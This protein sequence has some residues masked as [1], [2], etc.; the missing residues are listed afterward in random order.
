MTIS[1]RSAIS[2][3]G[4]KRDPATTF[5]DEMDAVCA[6]HTVHVSVASTVLVM[7]IT[8]TIISV[9]AFIVSA[10]TAWL[11]LL[12]RGALRMTHPTVIFFGPDGPPSQGAEIKIFLRTLLYSTAKHAHILESLYVTLRRGESVQ[13][14]N[15]WVYGDHSPLLRGSG[16]R[17][18]EDGFA[19]NHHFVLPKDGTHYAFIAGEYT[20][21]VYATLVNSKAVLMSKTRL[22]LTQEHATAIGRGFGVYFDWG[23]DSKSYH[24]HIDSRPAYLLVASASEPSITIVDITIPAP[25][26]E[27]KGIEYP[28]KCYVQL[29]NDSPECADI[30]ISEFKPKAVTLKKFPVDVLQ[31]KLREWSPK[32]EGVDHVAILPGQLF[33]AWIGADE[34]KFTHDQLRELRGRIG[35][36]VFFVNGQPLNI[37]V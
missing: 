25:P 32:D 22:Q 14:F 5:R 16:L 31:V 6:A 20:V 17:I 7:P 26:S 21:E 18:S 29:R 19:T 1:Q 35:T 8:A 36:I 13:T 3:H 37:D 15:I 34:S 12:R 30:R 11:T 23:P 27:G 9:L 10:A 2:H 24:A 28:L 33:R 4:A